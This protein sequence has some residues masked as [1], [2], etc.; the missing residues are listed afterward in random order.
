[1]D[2]EIHP[3]CSASDTRIHPFGFS[4]AGGAGRPLGS[5]KIATG[6]GKR[7]LGFTVGEVDEKGALPE[8]AGEDL[9]GGAN[10][11]VSSPVKHE[12]SHVSES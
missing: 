1:M 10:P 4:L 6:P 12:A 3:V 9:L 8:K 7:D 5:C 2:G 11:S